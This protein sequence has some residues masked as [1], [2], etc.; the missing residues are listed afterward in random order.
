MVGLLKAYVQEFKRE[1]GNEGLA[2]G[3]I[4]ANSTKF[5][6][7]QNLSNKNNILW[8][9]TYLPNFITCTHVSTGS[10]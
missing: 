5:E 7:V 4:L 2:W 8:S 9:S 3:S 6:S 1:E 10:P